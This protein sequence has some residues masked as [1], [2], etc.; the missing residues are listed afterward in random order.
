VQ[1]HESTRLKHA[2]YMDLKRFTEF[3]RSKI[4]AGYAIEGTYSPAQDQYCLKTRAGSIDD[5]GANALD[6]VD[7]ERTYSVEKIERP[8]YELSKYYKLKTWIKYKENLNG[9]NEGEW[10]TLEFETHQIPIR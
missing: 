10:K 7:A 4:A 1:H 5:F 9:L 8:N 2:A 6:C 3:Y